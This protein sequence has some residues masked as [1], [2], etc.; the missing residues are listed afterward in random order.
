MFLPR[1][2]PLSTIEEFQ[3]SRRKEKFS[4]PEVGATRESPPSGYTVDHNQVRLGFGADAFRR[5]VESVN[6]WQMF[7]LGW[8]EVFP[9][10]LKIESGATVAILVH[11]FGF[12]SLNAC[13][14][15]YS[16]AEERRYGFA[17]G[18]LM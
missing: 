17:Y 9:K 2:P 16:I 7:D 18:T 11:H 10:K 3:V 13:R 4:Y 6:S 1:K 12:W 14:I 5:A 8:I 15:I